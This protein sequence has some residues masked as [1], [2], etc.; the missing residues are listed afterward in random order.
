MAE[1]SLFHLKQGKEFEIKELFKDISRL[2][3]EHFGEKTDGLDLLDVGCASGELSYFMKKDTGTSGKIQ[4]FDISPTLIK[5]AAERFGD[6]GMKFFIADAADFKLDTKFDVI[7]MTS[8]LSYFDDPYP[9]LKNM[10]GH[11]KKNGLAIISGIFNEHNIEVRL[12]YKLES[13][14]EW[15]DNSVINQFSMKGISN[16]LADY[17]Y[18]AEFMKQIMPFD[19]KPK[20]NPIRSWTVNA[21]GVRRMT[22]GL[23]LLYDIQILKI[24][25]KK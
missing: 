22:N 18:Q 19:V 20:E 23:Q 24:I 15:I 10:L 3:K 17:G 16:F 13:D 25:D 8:V 7:T 11:L 12:K 9:V 6:E 2:T 21:D 4:G 5:N 1:K 14:N